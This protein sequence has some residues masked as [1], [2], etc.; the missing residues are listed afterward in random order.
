[1]QPGYFSLVEEAGGIKD[2]KEQEGDREASR[3]G[4]SPTQVWWESELNHVVWG[5]MCYEGQS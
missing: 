2:E 4:T 5:I 1:M 3:K